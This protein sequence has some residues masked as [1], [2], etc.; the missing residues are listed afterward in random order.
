MR[1]KAVCIA[2]AITLTGLAGCGGAGSGGILELILS[3]LE[4]PSHE[5]LATER[6]VGGG[7]GRAIIARERVPDYLDDASS[8]GLFGLAVQPPDF[9]RPESVERPSVDIIAVTLATLDTEILVQDLRAAI[10][11]MYSDGRWLAWSHFEENR[12]RVIDLE[13]GLESRLF[14]EMAQLAYVHLVALDAGYLVAR[15]T[16]RDERK[17]VVID[18]ATGDH[19][20]EVDDVPFAL[21]GGTLAFV[22][23]TESDPKPRIVLLNLITGERRTIVASLGPN[24]QYE[25]YLAEGRVIWTE[26]H[27]PENPDAVFYRSHEIESDTTEIIAELDPYHDSTHLA[28]VGPIGLLWETMPLPTTDNPFDLLNMEMRVTFELVTFDGQQTIISDTARD[29]PNVPFFSETPRIL[30]EYV[31]IRD[32]FEGD[33]IV[34]DATNRSN[35]RFDPSFACDSEDPDCPALVVDLAPWE[36]DPVFDIAPWE[37]DWDLVPGQP[38]GSHLARAEPDAG[39]PGTRQ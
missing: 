7:A 32:P 33:Y 28:A 12:I 9:Q 20:E 34:Y 23:G 8:N 38:V 22:A 30:G 24:F 2:K 19:L 17:L 26:F 29:F 1:F 4:L 16:K 13:T 37:I 25:I 5:E 36:P 14:E 6:V 3:G 18:L 10:Y 31:L 39:R 15:V 27:N 11:S 21:S 35:R